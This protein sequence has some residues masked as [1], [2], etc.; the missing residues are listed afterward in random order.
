[1]WVELGFNSPLCLSNP[2]LFSYGCSGWLGLDV[3]Q[4]L[5]DVTAST[6][7]S[8]IRTIDNAHDL[9]FRTVGDEEESELAIRVRERRELRTCGALYDRREAN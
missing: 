3:A 5:L 9:S 8:Q 7:L 2:L 4:Q 6:S 1:M